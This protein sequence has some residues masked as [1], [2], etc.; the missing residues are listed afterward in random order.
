MRDVGGGRGN[1]YPLPSSIIHV[2]VVHVAGGCVPNCRPTVLVAIAIFVFVVVVVA[3]IYLV[4]AASARACSRV[5]FRPRRRPF[6]N[7]GGSI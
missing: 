1:L 2:V 7:G 4:R 3:N 6:S 5:S